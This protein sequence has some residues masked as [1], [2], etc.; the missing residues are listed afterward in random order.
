MDIASIYKI[1]EVLQAIR[2][3][4]GHTSLFFATIIPVFGSIE[5]CW[6]QIRREAQCKNLLG[7][8]EML[9]N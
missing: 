4:G 9:A 3:H 6:P 8:N 7:K 5:E 2:D 1:A